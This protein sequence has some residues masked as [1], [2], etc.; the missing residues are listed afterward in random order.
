MKS[1]VVCV[2]AA[3]VFHFC[4]RKSCRAH[5]VGP[6]STY[7]SFLGDQYVGCAVAAKPFFFT[8]RGAPH[9]SARNLY[10]A[11]VLLC[12]SLLRYFPQAALT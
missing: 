2:E 4:A 3:F 1:I 12:D 6:V 7:T 8:V 11:C 10:M 5:F 9:A